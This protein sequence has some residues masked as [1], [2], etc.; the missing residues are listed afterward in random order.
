MFLHG[1]EL[2]VAHLRQDELLERRVLRDRH[3][4]RFVGL[5]SGLAVANATAIIEGKDLAVFAQ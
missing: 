2:T 4:L 3:K 5:N 1:Y